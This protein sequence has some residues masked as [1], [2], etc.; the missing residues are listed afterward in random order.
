MPIHLSFDN[1][2]GFSYQYGIRGHKYRFNP[3][4]QGEDLKAYKLSAKQAGAIHAR[5]YY[6]SR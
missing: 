4:I 1:E 2:K 6:E 3:K 5:G